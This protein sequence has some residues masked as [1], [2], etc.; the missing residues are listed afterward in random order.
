MPEIKGQA[1]AATLLLEK[2][3]VGRVGK[4]KHIQGFGL[5]DEKFKWK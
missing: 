3:A 1:G 5:N 4:E 2:Q